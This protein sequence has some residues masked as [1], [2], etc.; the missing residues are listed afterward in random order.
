VNVAILA[1][2][3]A[4]R[5]GGLEKGLLNICGKKSIKRLLGTFYNCETVI[6]CRDNKQASLYSDMATAI[7][8]RY[9]NAGPLAG[10]HAALDYFR[11]R[12]L[13]VAVDMPFVK[14]TVA[15][16]IYEEA[17]KSKADALIP[18]WRDGKK[19]P[20]LA[21]YAYS[22]I[23]EIERGLIRGE[24]KIM[25]PVQRL[26]KVI[27]YPIDELR[28]VDENLVSFFNINMPEDVKRAEK[29]CSSIDLGGE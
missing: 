4:S 10:I 29:L 14:R 7:T 26:E 25:I 22:A 20:I 28:N 11:S 12:V 2:G 16:V 6:V 15:E 19:E 21:C 27:F 17:K 9:R 1:G 13:I 5:L 3:K 8:D 24:R 18:V 23:K